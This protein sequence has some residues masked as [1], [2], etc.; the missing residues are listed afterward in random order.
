MRD[1]LVA[2]DPG[3]GLLAHTDSYILHPWHLVTTLDPSAAL[4]LPP[5]L[6]HGRRTMGLQAITSRG[7]ARGHKEGAWCPF[8]LAQSKGARTLAPGY[9]GFS[10]PLHN[11]LPFSVAS[12]SGMSSWI[13]F[14]HGGKGDF[15]GKVQQLNMAMLPPTT[16]GLGTLDLLLP[17]APP[18]LCF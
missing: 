2:S 8:T 13:Q 9:L 7:L 10:P 1:T 3:L 14:G 5:H 4:L 17:S 16:G 11:T 12:T 6:L 18:F 15:P